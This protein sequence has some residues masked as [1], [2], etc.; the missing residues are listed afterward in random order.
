MSLRILGTLTFMSSQL[1]TGLRVW[2]RFAQ[3]IISTIVARGLQQYWSFPLFSQR[4]SAMQCIINVERTLHRYRLQRV[5]RGR[6]RKIIL[7]EPMRDKQVLFFTN[8]MSVYVCD[9]RIRGKWV[10]SSII[11]LLQYISRQWYPLPFCRYSVSYR[12]GDATIGYSKFYYACAANKMLGWYSMSEGK[13]RSKLKLVNMMKQKESLHVS[14]LP[15]FIVDY[16]VNKLQKYG[17]CF[18]SPLSATK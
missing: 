3:Q 12:G 10:F 11:L 2:Y 1:K 9:S 4:R 15:S 17:L 6:T 18:L 7:I 16:K 5:T 13:C 8:Q 14:Q